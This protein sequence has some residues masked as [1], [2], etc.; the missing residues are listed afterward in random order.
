MAKTFQDAITLTRQYLDEAQQADWLDSEVNRCINIAYHK[1]AVGVIK[2]YQQFYET[3]TPFTYALVANQ[4]EYTIDPSLIKI[5][6]VEVN[7]QPQTA[8]SQP[9]RATQMKMDEDLIAVGNIST[10]GILFSVGYYLHG[11]LSNQKIGLVPIPQQSDTT[12]QSI[13]VWGIAIPI[14]LSA[15]TDAINIPYSDDYYQ[16]IALEAASILLQKGQQATKSADDYDTQ[17]KVGL[18]EMMELLY[19]RQSDGPN[20]IQDYNLE[21]LDFEVV[22]V[23]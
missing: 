23:Y 16:L 6:R 10:T 7:L 22:G 5:T 4:Q 15:T 14:D 17:F 20:M 8:N 21:N 2:V 19:E 18:K 11:S 1:V 12:K 3:T 9:M 13:A